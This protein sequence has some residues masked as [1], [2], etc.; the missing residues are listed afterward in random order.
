[1]SAGAAP[2]AAPANRAPE[3]A[4]RGLVVAA[5]I[6]IYTVWGST[7][8]AIRYAVATLPPFLMAGARFLFAGGLM[9][10]WA[11]L[12]G[13]PAPTRREWK[14]TIIIGALLLLGGNGGVVW[15]ETRVTSSL[16][17]LLVATVPLWMA[18]GDWLRPRGVR[19]TA[20]TALGLALGFGGVVVLIGPR[21]LVG[22]GD[23]SLAGVIAIML[24]CMA[25][26]GGSLYARS[27]ELPRSPVLA[28]GM[29]MLAGGVLMT[30]LGLVRSE[31]V[32]LT[33][34]AFTPRALAALGYLVVA[35]SLLG[36]TSYVWLLRVSTPARVGTY[37]YVNPVIA[38]LLGTLIAGET[39]NPRAALAAVIIVSAVVVIVSAKKEVKVG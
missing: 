11:R 29:E 21:N 14:S 9:L 1:M 13:A 38:V 37:A 15:A 18:L 34:A 31:H 33:A 23:V 20:R 36:F 17:A 19:P 28:T 27:A 22:G 10:G 24:G 16:A 6:C 5:F 35:G 7:Y 39:L 12:R 3:A 25:W 32:G 4:P 2:A 30:L 26:A 8:L